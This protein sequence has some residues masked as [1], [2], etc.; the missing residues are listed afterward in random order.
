MAAALVELLNGR[1]GRARH[2]DLLCCGKR[3]LDLLGC[4]RR[5][6]QQLRCG[7]TA[8]PVV[9]W[10]LLIC[11]VGSHSTALAGHVNGASKQAGRRACPSLPAPKNAD[12]KNTPMAIQYCP[13]HFTIYFPKA[14]FW[15]VNRNRGGLRRATGKRPEARDGREQAASSAANAGIS[16]KNKGDVGNQKS[17]RGS[18]ASAAGGD[19]QECRTIDQYRSSRRAPRPGR[20]MQLIYDNAK[21]L[22]LVL[23]AIELMHAYEQ[24]VMPRSVL[25]EGLIPVV[26]RGVPTVALATRTA[27]QR[28]HRK[29]HP[30]SP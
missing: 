16:T 9:N 25:R 1:S 21:E 20:P 10:H 15:P 13:R 19:Q 17:E 27:M 22:E 12:Q 18:K 14:C 5:A 4:N 3:Q 24:H 23:G 2:D 26:L 6:G 28:A 7:R 29:H 30:H 8:I 11:R